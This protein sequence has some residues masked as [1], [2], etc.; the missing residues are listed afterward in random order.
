[1]HAASCDRVVLFNEA[2]RAR[3]VVGWSVGFDTNFKKVCR[4]RL[5]GN[6]TDYEKGSAPRLL[7]R[8]LYSPMYSTCVDAAAPNTSPEVAP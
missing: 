6:C 3:Y 8:Q 1:M 7:T 5:G 2:S 4:H